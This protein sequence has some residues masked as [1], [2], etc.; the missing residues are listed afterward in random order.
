MTTS[1]GL[2]LIDKPGGLTSHDVV[3]RLRKLFNE[4]RIGHAGTLDPMATGLLVVAVGPSTR[5]L[6][7]A[8]S[9]SKHYIGTVRLG[10]A[11]DS[12]DAD[13]IVVATSEVPELSIGQVNSWAGTMLG[14]QSQ[15]PPMV[16]ALKVEGRRLHELARE[17]IEVERA[18]R[19]IVIDSFTLTPGELKGDWD[20]DVVC[21]VGT[22]VRVL[23]SDLSVKMG[24]VG[25]LTAL[26][27]IASGSHHV[28]DAH[29][30]EEL[31]ALSDVASVLS[32]PVHLVEGLET[33][34]LEVADVVKMRMGQ[35]LGLDETFTG[36]EIAALDV[37]GELVGVLR[38]RGDLWKPEIVLAPR[39]N[40]Q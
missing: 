39:G 2:L 40:G 23:L 21:S 5:L 8:Q 33:R 29:S 22:Y 20:F 32:S 13:G 19:D 6:R 30:L 9:Q 18:S 16:S 38:R 25:H 27:R 37:E 17:G 35:R 12:L 1:S 26:R 7:F 11:T 36:D 14:F 3:A 10:E 34:N 15:V 24:T 4:R 31:S 28:R